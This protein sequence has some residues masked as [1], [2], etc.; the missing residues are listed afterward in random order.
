MSTVLK[1]FFRR[2]NN[3][4]KFVSVFLLLGKLKLPRIHKLIFSDSGNL[5]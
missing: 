5:F 1:I 3:N 2:F 4:F